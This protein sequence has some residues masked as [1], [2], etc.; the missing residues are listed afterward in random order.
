MIGPILKWAGGK[1]S[2]IPHI[3]RLFPRDYGRHPYHEPF[4]GGGA[5]FFRIRPTAGAIND[6]NPRLMNFYR[7]VRDRP[8]ELIAQAR[9]YRYDQ[10]TYYGLRDR[11]N[12]RDLPDVEAAALLLYLNK[13]SYNGLYRVNSRGEFNVPF[14]RYESP[15]IVPEER[16]RAASK[17]LGN[18]DVTC[19]DFASAM[20]RADEGDIC[21]LDPPYQPVSRTANF[22]SYAEGGFDLGKQALLRDAC[23]ELDERGVLFVQSNSCTEPILDLYRGIDSFRIDTIQAKRPISANP[24][25]RGPASEVLISNTSTKLAS[26]F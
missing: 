23:V 24:S 12:R 9:Q 19:E 3:M 26:R 8:E 20:D 4:F 22:T 25:T 5:L 21:Y 18:V 14:G 6:I 13:T 16:I 2:M 17:I 7:V 10:E 11:F 1:R 15:R